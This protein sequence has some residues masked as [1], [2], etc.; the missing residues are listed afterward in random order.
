MCTMIA[1]QVA[2]DGSGKGTAGWFDVRQA[3]VSY[4]H[5]FDVPLEHALNIDFVNEALGPGARVAVELSTESAQALVDDDPGG[6]GA[7]RSRRFLGSPGLSLEAATLMP[8]NLVRTIFF[9]PTRTTA[10]IV[11]AIAYGTRLHA[12]EP[13]DL[14]PPEARTREWAELDDEFVIIGAPVYG[15]RIA[16]EA[17][18]RLRRLRACTKHRPVSSWSTATAPTTTRSWSCATS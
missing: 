3:N 4:D 17:A 11:E 13:F 16:S 1:Q 10:H 5:P 9:S 6:A 7:G 2:I 12:A 14:T 15:G 18:L 8:T